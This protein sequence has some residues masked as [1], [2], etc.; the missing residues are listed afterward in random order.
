MHHG[1]Y[2]VF[3]LAEVAVPRAL[4]AEIGLQ[5]TRNLLKTQLKHALKL[6]IK[7]ILRLINIQ[8]RRRPLVL[9]QNRPLLRCLRNQRNKKSAHKLTAFLLEQ[10]LGRINENEGTVFIAV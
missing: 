4:F 7:I 10:I 6:S 2:V 3:Q 8:K 5:L 1:R 9:S